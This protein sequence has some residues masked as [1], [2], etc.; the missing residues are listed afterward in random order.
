MSRTIKNFAPMSSPATAKEDMLRA[1]VIAVI[2]G[3]MAFLIALVGCGIGVAFL[4]INMVYIA[5][6][7]S[8]VWMFFGGLIAAYTV[9]APLSQN[10][11]E[12]REDNKMIRDA[13]R[14]EREALRIELEARKYDAQAKAASAVTMAYR[15]IVTNV[16]VCSNSETTRAEVALFEEESVI[17]EMVNVAGVGDVNVRLLFDAADRWPVSR[18]SLRD[19]GIKFRNTE[20]G[21]V[22]K[23]FDDCN[24]Y[25][26]AQRKAL[27]VTRQLYLGFPY[28]G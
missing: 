16:P 25:M 13:S 4:D 21:A 26:D 28:P 3:L 7:V 6:C 2:F 24:T 23:V 18:E 10:M 11:A 9:I 20:Y 22:K 27:Q 17:P 1:I 8:L 19:S 15:P 14:D 12:T 5:L